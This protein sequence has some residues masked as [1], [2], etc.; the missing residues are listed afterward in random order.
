MAGYVGAT[1][2]LNPTSNE[3]R[4]GSIPSEVDFVGFYDGSQ[5]NARQETQEGLFLIPSRIDLN[6]EDW[7][8]TNLTPNK[9][10]KPHNSA[11]V[12]FVFPNIDGAY[13]RSVRQL[14]QAGMT[15]KRLLPGLEGICESMKFA[16]LE[17]PKNLQSYSVAP[18]AP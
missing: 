17:S 8:T 7:L 4:I 14:V 5:L 3:Y 12:E 18:S 1:P 6:I 16:W 13:Y 15:A 10:I 2:P 11:W 9:A